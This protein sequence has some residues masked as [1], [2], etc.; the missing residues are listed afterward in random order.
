MN[1]SRT[2]TSG[3]VLSVL[4]TAFLCLA[5]ASGKFMDFEGKEEMF[6]HFGWSVD[7]MVSIGVVEVVI[8]LLFLIPRTAFVAAVLLT[9]YLG[10]ATATHV[11]V[12]DPFFFPIIICVVAWLAL[13]LRDSRVFRIAFQSP[14]TVDSSL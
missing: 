6:R 13:G 14:A 8:A 2:K 10:G 4:L 11:R 1:G 7:V 5:S 12:G 3:W 9:A